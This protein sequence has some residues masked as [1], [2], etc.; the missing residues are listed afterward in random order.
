[1]RQSDPGWFGNDHPALRRAW[2]PVARADE[3]MGSEPVPIELL[4]ERLVLVRLDGEVVVLPDRCPHRLAPLS[5]GVVVG[6]GAGGGEELRCAYH[7]YRFDGT[8]HCTA[9][10]ALGDGATIP[11]RAH[12][13]P[14]RSRIHQGMVWVALD[15]P[16]TD[17]L[18]VD[19]HDDASF[20]RVTL[21]PADWT[22]GAAQMVDNFLD[23]AHFPFT[24]LGTFGDPD[25]TVVEDYQ[26]RRTAEGWGFEV[27]HR[28]L[29][30]ALSGSGEL[31]HRIQAFTYRAPLTVLLRI[32]YVEEEVTLT[33]A[34]HHQPLG[35]GRT[36]LWVTD[37]RN[38]I[39]ES[40]IPDARAFQQAVGNE[41]RA[42][43]ERFHL[44]AIPLAPTGE[45][46]TRADRIT[47]ELRRVLG[48]F[49]A[50]AD[51]VTA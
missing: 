9:I 2:H 10:P 32:T 18:D 51:E 15:E 19:E 25:D 46:H 45:V 49:V 6:G 42:L 40:A 47:L 4:G 41:D 5:A 36:R 14:V 21:D 13:T 7:G 30:K 1:M 39:D 28:H 24:H 23:V 20:V 29:A 44:K 43:L 31:I 37:Y 38:D 34:F 26:V 22:A 27:E 33:I 16:L 48:A 12:L 11:P 35:P 3:A 17:L 50:N 8:G